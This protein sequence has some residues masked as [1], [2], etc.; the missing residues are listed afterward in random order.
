[1]KWWVLQTQK[2]GTKHTP[3]VGLEPTTTRLRALRSTDWA[4]RAFNRDILIYIKYMKFIVWPSPTFWIT[5]Y[6][7]FKACVLVY[8]WL[9]HC[10]R[11]KL[12]Q[13]LEATSV[14]WSRKTIF[15]FFLYQLNTNSSTKF[16][17]F[18][19]LYFFAWSNM[20]YGLW[21]G[22][23][24]LMWKYDTSLVYDLRGRD[25]YQTTP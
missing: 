15:F 1:M 25:I 3:T 4:R 2:I 20:L 10:R 18:M 8:I 17:A 22:I 12:C 9:K 14:I 21:R 7:V 19:L 23:K 5:S 16:V 11:T 24:M 13:F 6:S